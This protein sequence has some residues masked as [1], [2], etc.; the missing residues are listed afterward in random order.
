MVIVPWT[1]VFLFWKAP[2]IAGGIL[3]G[4]PSLTAGQV[5][6]AGVG[7]ALVAGAAAGVVNAGGRTTLRG[8]SQA[9]NKVSGGRITLPAPAASRQPTRQAL[10]QT[11]SHS[12]RYFAHDTE[13]G[14][15]NATLP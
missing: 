9:T 15:A 3:A 13:G 2:A 12:A 6:R 1:M 4:H 11:L 14:G 7:T 5:V 8:L 10:L